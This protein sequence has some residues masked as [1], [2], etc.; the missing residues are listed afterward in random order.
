[1]DERG[2]VPGLRR[3]SRQSAVSGRVEKGRARWNWTGPRRR[4]ASF[5]A[6]TRLR[7]VEETSGEAKGV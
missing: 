1:M 3:S 4:A 5:R 6:T 7:P 2:N